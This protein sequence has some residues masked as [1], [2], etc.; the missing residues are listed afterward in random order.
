MV[1]IKNL[2][3]EPALI[4]SVI[5]AGI[6]LAVTFGLHVST[7][8]VTLIM[9]AVTATLGLVTAW[10]TTHTVLSV[11]LGFA[12]AILALAVGFGLKLGADQT[13]AIIAFITVGLGLFNRTQNS[14][15]LLLGQPGNDGAGV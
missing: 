3:G 14:P 6:A 7:D 5:G 15:L 2:F 11:F 9:A 8:Q 1:R 12:K 10:L 4:I 13:A